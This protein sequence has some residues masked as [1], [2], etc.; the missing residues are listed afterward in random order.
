MTDF[1]LAVILISAI[2]MSGVRRVKL[3]ISGYTVQA[4]CI[5]IVSF[6]T[7][8]STN[9]KH[10]YVISIMTL[11]AKVILVPLILTHSVRKIKTKVE[12]SPV[13]NSFWSYTLTIISI[14][15]ASYISAGS[16][17][18]YIKEAISLS[19]VGALLLIGRRKALSQMIGFLVIE[20]GLMLFELSLI[21]LSFLIEFAIVVEAIILFV[22]MAIVIVNINA[23]FDTTN[24]DYLSDLKE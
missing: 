15:L 13:L 21:K 17:I 10:Y 11:L 6:L 23:A 14:A 7:A 3:L 19:I 2:L 9:D 20:N 12:L 22:I 4:F 16:G 1:F 24:T 5:F 18:L 8:L